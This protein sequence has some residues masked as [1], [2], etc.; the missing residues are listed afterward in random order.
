MNLPDLSQM[1]GQEFFDWI[2]NNLGDGWA[3]ALLSTAT[4][5]IFRLQLMNDGEEE[6]GFRKC[7]ES[8]TLEGAVKGAIEFTNKVTVNE[9]MQEYYKDW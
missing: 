4:P 5:G 3:C 2:D 6:L 7:I 8:E 9:Y 1:Q